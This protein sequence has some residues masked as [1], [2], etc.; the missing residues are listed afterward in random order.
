MVETSVGGAIGVLVAA[1]DKFDRLNPHMDSGKDKGYTLFEDEL[2]PGE[3]ANGREL[4]DL[5]ADLERDGV[6][7]F[8][9]P[10]IDFDKKEEEPEDFADFDISPEVSDK[11]TDPVRMYLREMGTVPLLTREGEIDLAKRIE[12]GQTA[13]M[14]ALSRSPLVV[15]DILVM[16]AEVAKGTLPVRDILV[17]PDPPLTDEFVDAE[18]VKLA[19]ALAEIERHYRKAQ[20]FQQKMLA[21]SRGMKPKQ[22]RSLRWNL[23]RTTIRI[24]RLI[25]AVQFTTPVRHNLIQCVR[26]SVEQFKPLEREIAR[27]QR[28][29]EDVNAGAS[30]LRKDTQ[31]KPEE[32][33]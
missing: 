29:L 22:H 4:D 13:V 6:D 8:E 1:D 18:T 24:S 5:L 32:H 14:K 31:A 27:A 15:R 23:S 33:G 25:R 28:Q 17:L 20:Q 2:L 11:T 19:E 30:A 3:V 10:K 12:R 9:D 7:I 16:G 21:V 26:Q